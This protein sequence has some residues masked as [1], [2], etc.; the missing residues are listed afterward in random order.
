MEE[1]NY[2]E[3]VGES[4]DSCRITVPPPLPSAL[5]KHRLR[6]KLAKTSFD[7]IQGLLISVW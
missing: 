3:I 6:L 4:K 2:A 1:V 5:Q 7:D